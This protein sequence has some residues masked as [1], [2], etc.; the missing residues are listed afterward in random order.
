MHCT[1]YDSPVGR[2]VLTCTEDALTGL[3]MNRDTPV[4]EEHPIFRQT[5]LWLDAYFRGERPTLE[6]PL[7]A[8]GTPFQQ[9][10]WQLLLEIPYGKTKTYGDLAREMTAITGRKMSAQAVGQAVG[11]NPISIL[12]PCH[13]VIGAKGNLTG[14]AGGLEKKIW[15]LRHE[16]RQIEKDIVL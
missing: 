13:R 8:E 16:G 4:Q 15:L 14:Y 5:K 3:Y 7:F 11:R 12:I 10:I 6:L 2:L 1:F 9:K